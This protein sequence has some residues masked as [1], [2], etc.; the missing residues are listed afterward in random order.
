M[1]ITKKKKWIFCFLSL[2]VIV[3][4]MGSND[5]K[6]LAAGV[7]KLN[8]KTVTLDPGKRAS[9]RFK[10]KISKASIRWYTKNPTVAT[11]SCKGVVVA[12]NPGRTDV[13]CKVVCKQKRKK[14]TYRLICKVKVNDYKNTYAYRRG[15]NVADSNAFEL[16][17][18]SEVAPV[19]QFLYKNEGMAYAYLQNKKLYI[20]TP[21]REF[22]I[23][24]KYPLLGDVISDEA[25]NFYVIR[26]RKNATN[27]A[28]V[29]TTF[30]TKYDPD[31]KEIKTTGFVGRC[32]PWGDADKAKTK[33][34]FSDGN[35][36]SEIHDGILVCY[37]AK[38]R[39]DGHQSDQVIAVDTATMKEY[40]LPNNAY[41]GHSFDQAVIYSDQAKDFVFASLGDC[42]SRGFRVNRP[43]GKYGDDDGIIFH[44]YLKA[45]AGYNME[46]VNETF[47]Q[48]AG[49]GETSA[50]LV[51][52]GA[53]VKALNADAAKQKQNLF[54]QI[55]NPSFEKITKDI[56]VNGVDRKGNTALS[57]YDDKLTPIT[58]H[59]VIWLTDHTDR[60]VVAP[61]MITAD[62]KIIVMWSELRENTM[63]AYYMVLSESGVVIKPRTYIGK[64][65][66]NSYE[67]PVYFDQKIFWA[68]SKDRKIRVKQL[69]LQ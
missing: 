57:M 12:V 14:K 25:G 39:Y 20:I 67:K 2:V 53:S 44:S 48:F 21:E 50:G 8:A 11:V 66:L 60:D 54:L 1:K 49:L 13:I 45:N 15:I 35:C 59:G 5:R 65:C 29:P 38:E 52:A 17:K 7:P 55:F 56:F 22:A 4:V 40:T 34:P 16:P 62:D 23:A 26:G 46:I 68:Y 24:S 31:G 61:K 37:H 33:I 36:V 64:N 51:L 27:D 58:D 69:S 18:W 19:Q 30:I 63:K 6:S 9:I 43:D 10:K 42:Y 3:A 41:S 28:T 47:A 32:I